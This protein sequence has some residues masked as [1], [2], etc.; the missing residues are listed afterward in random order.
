MSRDVD[1][2]LAQPRPAPRRTFGA[3]RVTRAALLALVALVALAGLVER[4]H[5][6]A[7]PRPATSHPTSPGGAPTAPS[8]G[9]AGPA[10]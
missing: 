10:G 2:R 9:G 5:R 1:L 4:G 6:D 7:G 3:R 8:P